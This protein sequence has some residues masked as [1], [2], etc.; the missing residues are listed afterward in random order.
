MNIPPRLQP[1]FRLATSPYA[2]HKPAP[3]ATPKFASNTSGGQSQQGD[4]EINRHFEDEVWE[5]YGRPKDK[6]KDTKDRGEKKG[7]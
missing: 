3:A 6:P 2:A 4:S 1:A 5:R 7:S